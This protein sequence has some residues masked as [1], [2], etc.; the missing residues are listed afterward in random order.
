LP[1]AGER[2]GRA[3]LQGLGL[4]PARDVERILKAG[5]GRLRLWLGE[6]QPQLTF[7]QPGWYVEYGHPRPICQHPLLGEKQQ[8]FLHLALSAEGGA[9]R[10][11]RKNLDQGRVHR[12]RSG[13]GLTEVPQPC[14][15]P[16]LKRLC[17]A[18]HGQALG[19]PE[20]EAFLPRQVT[21]GLPRGWRTAASRRTWS[22]NAHACF[23]CFR[24]EAT[25]APN[26]STIPRAK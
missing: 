2:H 11:Q 25:R 24:A 13:D 4:L 10:D 3:Q 8:S 15:G 21:S 14:L 1:E 16:S 26:S 18:P 19:M 5:L 17:P 20:V 7:T 6:L 12:L 9:K 23:R 22:S